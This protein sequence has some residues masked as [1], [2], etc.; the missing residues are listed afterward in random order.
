M[1]TPIEFIHLLNTR[2]AAHRQKLSRTAEL[3]IRHTQSQI[4]RQQRSI[5]RLQA[6]W[7]MIALSV[8]SLGQIAP[9][10]ANTL[11]FA[12]IRQSLEQ[13]S[14][15][16]QSLLSAARE[17]SSSNREPFL[18]V[19]AQTPATPTTPT[20]PPPTNTV[21]GKLINNINQPT[22]VKIGATKRI[23][24]QQALDIAARNNRE[25]QTARLTIAKSQSDVREAEAAKNVQVGLSSTLSAQGS[26][27]IT[28]PAPNQNTNLTTN[29]SGVVEATYSLINQN[30]D[31]RIES[32]KAQVKFDSADL[33]RIQR[34]IKSAVITAY[35]DLQ[36][37][38]STIVINN[39]A[40]QDATRSLSDAQLQEKAGVGT[41]FDILRSQVQL[42]TANQDLTNSQGQQRTARRK[43]AQLLSLDDTTDFQ[44]ADAVSQ[45]GAWNSTLED[46]ILLAF[47]NRAEIRQ[48]EF[49][50]KLLSFQDEIRGD[51]SAQVNLFANY[52]LAKTISNNNPAQDSYS[53]GAQLRW[54]F[55]D[56]GGSAA[57]SSRRK[58]NDDISD[59]QVIIV[60]NQVRFEVE[61]AF[62]TLGS[63]QKN[64]ATATQA[65]QQAEE[66]LKLARLRFQAGVGTQTDVIQSQTELARSRGNRIT[67]ILNYNRALS[68]LRT[69]TELAE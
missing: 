27:V 36:Q 54:N 15:N 35:Y 55:W 28:T 58:V 46:S 7:A 33:D 31:R 21:D 44:A 49:R 68:I 34:S 22:T 63:S 50:K 14:T 60:R 18:K 11:D 29:V 25:V 67:A 62:N 1:L 41:R 42:A 4:D 6:I 61:Q 37:S 32:A 39:A 20:P 2:I 66:S 45:L 5:I 57:R 47:K 17:R 48:Q 30:L 40:V 10:R 12:G 56:G 53:L 8:G 3:P 16:Q 38:D 24:L 23:T 59:S 51:D 19:I 26:P 52:N 64:I 69:A 9:V 43:I 13:P 65:L